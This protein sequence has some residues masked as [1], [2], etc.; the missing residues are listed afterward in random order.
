MFKLFQKKE[1]KKTLEDL[2]KEMENRPKLGSKESVRASLLDT[3]KDL[4]G[5]QKKEFEDALVLWDKDEHEFHMCPFTKAEYDEYDKE[6]EAL[7]DKM[8]TDQSKETLRTYH[9]MRAN[10]FEWMAATD[11]NAANK[12]EGNEKAEQIAY[13]WFHKFSYYASQAALN[14]RLS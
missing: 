9:E 5:L 1:K 7:N 2:K 6:F 11:L 14:G 4:K 13:M 12:T 10:Y 8:K 3:Y